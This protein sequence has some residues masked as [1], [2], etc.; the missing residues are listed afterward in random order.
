MRAVADSYGRPFSLERDSP[1]DLNGLMR[2]SPDF[3]HDDNE[4]EAEKAW[5]LQKDICPGPPLEARNT[6]I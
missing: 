2:F 1:H 3:E 5:N 4:K 6:G